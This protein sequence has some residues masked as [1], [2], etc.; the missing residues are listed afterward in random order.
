MDE[1]PC[2]S[3][4]KVVLG[5]A[6]SYCADCW[7]AG[8]Q[9]PTAEREPA[10]G[11]PTMSADERPKPGERRLKTPEVDAPKSATSSS[12]SSTRHPG[13]GDDNSEP[14]QQSEV[15]TDRTTTSGEPFDAEVGV[16]CLLIVGG[17][18]FLLLALAALAV[19]V[20]GQ[21]GHEKETVDFLV[22]L[23]GRPIA[24]LIVLAGSGFFFAMTFRLFVAEPVETD[25]IETTQADDNLPASTDH[26]VDTASESVS[27]NVRATESANLP[28]TSSRPNV[29]WSRKVQRGS[30]SLK[31]L[32][33]RTSLYL[34]SCG[35]WLSNLVTTLIARVVIEIEGRA[36]WMRTQRDGWT[37]WLTSGKLTQA[38]EVMDQASANVQFLFGL[39]LLWDW[40]VLFV[41][42]VLAAWSLYW[43]FHDARVRVTDGEP[44]GIFLREVRW[45]ILVNLVAWVG[46]RVAFGI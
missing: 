16:G 31:R 25:G 18:C 12:P 33:H 43:L 11:V 9:R 7:R 27:R 20:G 2:V 10:K 26:S 38:S 4:G 22:S 41:T 15:S 30:I 46:L 1:T 13:A 37:D 44:K 34:V 3:C 35:Y 23:V 5:S 45:V 29:D 28:K 6:G 19:F 17:V 39:L 8:R 36:S 24:G 21:F 32:R 40:L 42:C 14:R